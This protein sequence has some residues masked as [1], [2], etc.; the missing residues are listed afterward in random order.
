MC[1]GFPWRTNIKFWEKH[2][3]EMRKT[4]ILQA[5][6]IIYAGN[7]GG[8]ENAVYLA[9]LMEAEVNKQLIKQSQKENKT[10]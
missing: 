2:S 5:S 8:I 4:R 9:L 10:S 1:S 6:A 7:K 3:E